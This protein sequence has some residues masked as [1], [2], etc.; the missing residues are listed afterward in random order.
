MVGKGKEK[1]SLKRTGGVQ[2][3]NE[4]VSIMRTSLASKTRI[5]LRPM[6]SSVEN[7]I[8]LQLSPGGF[9]AIHNARGVQQRKR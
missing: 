1:G 2:G 7:D 3:M 4:P 5:D 8:F 6:Y 9:N